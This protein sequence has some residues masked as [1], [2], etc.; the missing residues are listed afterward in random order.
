MKRKLVLAFLASLLLFAPALVSAQS[1]FVQ[2]GLTRTDPCQMCDLVSM[3][4]RVVTWLVGILAVM[5]AIMFIVAGLKLVTSAGDVSA[6]EGAK[7]MIVNTFI[8]FVIV[9]AAWLLI[10]LMMQALANPSFF[11]DKATRVPWEVIECTDQPAA[12]YQTYTITQTSMCATVDDCAAQAAACDAGGG[13]G[14]VVTS[15]ASMSVECTRDTNSVNP[16]DLSAS[17]ACDSDVVSSYFPD[18]LGDAQCIIRGESTCGASMVSVTDVMRG[19][20][21]AFSFGPMQINLTYHELVGCGPGGS[22]LNCP[23][24]FSGRNY[25]ATV[26]DESLYMACATAA[27]NVDCGLSNGRRIQQRD[28]WRP[29]STAAGCGL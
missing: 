3:L 21:R 12:G 13:S 17:G 6:K 10:D 8:G 22:T 7:R 29:W 15:G 11:N 5:A 9:L 1:G 16:P 27:Q 20:G 19:D 28:G 14:T 25:S 18:N 24:A 2:C 26:V 23:D 4:D